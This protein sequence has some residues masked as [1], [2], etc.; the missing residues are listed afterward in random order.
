MKK[1]F[2][3]LINLKFF[4][5]KIIG[6]IINFNPKCNIC[7]YYSENTEICTIFNRNSMEARKNEILCGNEGEFFREKKLRR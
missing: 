3:K 4:E 5:K 6:P 2:V 7:R 1:Y